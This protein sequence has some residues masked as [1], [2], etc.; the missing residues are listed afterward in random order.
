MPGANNSLTVSIGSGQP[1]VVGTRAFQL[2]ATTSPTDLT[3]VEVGYMTGDKIVPMP[4]SALGGG[5]LGGTLEFRS[6]SLDKIQ[7]SLGRIAIGLASTFNAQHRL[8]IDMEGKPGGDFFAL[9]APVVGKNINNNATSTTAVTAAITD[10][11]RLT[12][13]DYKIEYDGASFTVVRLS[14]RQKTTIAPYPQGGVP[15]TIDG[16]AFSING[17]AAAGDNF[18][19][20]PTISGASDFKLKLSDVSQIAAATPIATSAP[21]TNTGTGK[22]SAGT[23]DASYLAGPTA[24]PFTLQFNS[25]SG[26]LS[27]FPA[28]PVTVDV[29]GV[30][31]T[32]AAGAAV[33]FSAGAGYSVG[34]INFSIGGA[35]ANGDQFRIAVNQ[36]GVGDT[37]NMGLLGKLQTTNIFN[38][39]SASYQSAYAELVSLVGNKTREVQV[40]AKAGEALLAQ[41]TG[42]A[43]DVA[44]VNLDEEASNL[45]KYQQ[46]YQAAG[47]VMQIASTIFDTLLSIGR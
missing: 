10:P 36:D 14:D 8:G 27:G 3:R 34:G 22:I 4:D 26:Q 7:N 18:V 1:L 38:G 2:V 13:S 12:A 33:P 15:Q 39:G 5:E 29:G 24:A 23:I 17:S 43:Q 41:A 32:Y 11:T 25:G 16:I 20:R 35:P 40:N 37:R 28:Q 42:A 45:L 47:K 19:V 6:S 31:T 21:V 46:A 44:G 9:P 30:K